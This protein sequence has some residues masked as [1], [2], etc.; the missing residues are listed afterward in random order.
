MRETPLTRRRQM[1]L[2]YYDYRQAGHY[3]ITICTH[4]RKTLFGN[5]E[6]G[7]IQLN[8][9]G[10]MI[11]D[12]LAELDSKYPDYHISDQTIMPN[13]IHFI[14]VNHQGKTDL[15]AA[16]KCGSKEKQRVST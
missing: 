14:W 7:T 15:S 5:I 4:S 1:R 12:T 6:N 13:H 3:F 2:K 9:T 10:K 16:I 8:P 11:A